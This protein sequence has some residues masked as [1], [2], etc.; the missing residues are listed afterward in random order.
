MSP[1]SKRA[2]STTQTADRVKGPHRA[3]VA[4]AA[5]EDRTIRK[6]A[7]TT[8]PAKIHTDL[9]P[10][11]LK[12]LEAIG[13][14]FT[15]RD[16]GENDPVVRHA[17]LYDQI[18]DE[19][20]TTQQAAEL[21]EVNES[22]IRQRLTL[23][24]PTLFGIKIGHEWRIPLFQFDERKRLIPGIDRVVAA[25]TPALPPVAFFLWFTTPS[26]DLEIEDDTPVSPKDWLRT[27]NSIDI[28]V[29]TASEL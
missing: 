7:R 10:S 21:L 20:L 27:G 28:I 12:A 14:D 26:V 25:I 24:P 15:P 8:I 2:R 16:L 23:H 3:R 13:A 17:K 11:Q 1:T 9:P 18:V 29:D 22:R 19:S 4:I 6:T 5:G